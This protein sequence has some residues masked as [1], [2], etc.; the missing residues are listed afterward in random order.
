M[1]AVLRVWLA[2]VGVGLL[3]GLLAGVLFLAGLF[4]QRP[5]LFTAALIALIASLLGF[6][7]VGACR[8]WLL[9]HLGVWTGLNGKRFSRA[10][11]PGWF[12]ALLATHIIIAAVWAGVASFLTWVLVSPP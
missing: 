6:A 2:A 1:Q 3:G 9:S 4:S 8:A 7:A 10:E 5:M 11:R 12:K